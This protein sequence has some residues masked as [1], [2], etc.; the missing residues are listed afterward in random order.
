MEGGVP[1]RLRKGR[2]TGRPC[3]PLNTPRLS[4]PPGQRSRRHEALQLKCPLQRRPPSALAESCLR[5]LILQLLPEGQVGAGVVRTPPTVCHGAGPC[6]I[7]PLPFDSA[8]KPPGAAGEPEVSRVSPNLPHGGG[9]RIS[10]AAEKI[11]GVVC[12]GSSSRQ[13]HSGGFGGTRESVWGFSGG[14]NAVVA[15]VPLMAESPGNTGRHWDSSGEDGQSGRNT[16]TLHLS[17]T[18]GP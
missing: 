8:H 9:S 6:P 18:L 5:R 3:P 11:P 15:P 13:S 4:F 1:L 16:L 7:P 10:Q 14:I 2:P 12:A 17:A